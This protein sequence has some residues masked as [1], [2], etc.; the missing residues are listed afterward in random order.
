MKPVATTQRTPRPARMDVLLCSKLVRA[1]TSPLSHTQVK[2]SGRFL[3]LCSLRP[4]AVIFDG[5]PLNDFSHRQ[6]N[7]GV[8]FL[9]MELPRGYTGTPRPLVVRWDKDSRAHDGSGGASGLGRLNG[10]E[11]P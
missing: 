6:T 8:P 7:E 5:A 1:H 2:G 11:R 9:E 3:A 4:A 10:S